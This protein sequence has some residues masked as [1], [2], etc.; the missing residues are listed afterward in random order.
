MV[1]FYHEACVVKGQDQH[2]CRNERTNENC[3]WKA[4][5]QRFDLLLEAKLTGQSDKGVK[6]LLPGS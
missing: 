2:R 4:A 3:A 6:G 1:E 5:L